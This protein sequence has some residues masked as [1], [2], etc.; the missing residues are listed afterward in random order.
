MDGV[1]PW[2]AV[3]TTPGKLCR[4]RGRAPLA[5][6]DGAGLEEPGGVLGGGAAVVVVEG[7][8]GAD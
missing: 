4:G 1:D 2:G 8:A 7:G 3:G 6:L 5:A